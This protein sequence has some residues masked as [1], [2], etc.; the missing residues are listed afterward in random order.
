MEQTKKQPN[1]IAIG[2]VFLCLS[3]IFVVMAYGYGEIKQL[4]YDNEFY[5]NSVHFEGLAKELGYTINKIDIK[6]TNKTTMIFDIV[7][8]T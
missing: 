3:I 2:M 7:N 1:V 4:K 8:T 5:H 6:P